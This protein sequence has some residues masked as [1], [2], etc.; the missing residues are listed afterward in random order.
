VA[1]VG[2][3]DGA[4]TGAVAQ[5]AASSARESAA[6]KATEPERRE[7]GDMFMEPKIPYPPTEALH[8]PAPSV[9]TPS[10]PPA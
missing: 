4:T 7:R 6:T 1:G 10:N 5:P 2:A 9:D 8:A 3:A